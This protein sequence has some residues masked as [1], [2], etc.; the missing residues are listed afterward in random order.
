MVVAYPDLKLLSAVLVLLG[1]FRVVFP[2]RGSAIDR[3]SVRCRDT[4][5]VISLVLMIL[6]ISS[7]IVE[8]THTVPI[9]SAPFLP[10]W[11]VD[12]VPRTLFADQ[13]VIAVVGVVGISC[14]CASAIAN[15]PE[16]E[17]CS[18]VSSPRGGMWLSGGHK[19]RNS[20]PKRPEWP[21]LCAVSKM[22]ARAGRKR[23]L[24][25]PD[26]ER[27]AVG[28]HS[29]G[30]DVRCCPRRRVRAGPSATRLWWGTEIPP[31]A[32]HAGFHR[33]ARAPLRPPGRLPPGCRQLPINPRRAPS[34]LR[35]RTK[36]R[37]QLSL[38]DTCSS[39]PVQAPGQMSTK[40]NPGTCP[41]AP[42]RT[43]FSST[44]PRLELASTGHH[45]ET[46]GSPR[47]VRRPNRT[48]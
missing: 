34:R 43:P 48:I 44:Q 18:D 4:N 28:R 2:A 36:S 14:N 8:L 39:R 13:T 7:M 16:V 35:G 37:G 15:D 20:C 22:K 24:L 29:A 26:V 19:P 3:R 30:W 9:L 47:M 27:L 41:T 17:L 32:F 12:R 33:L 46:T 25:V 45:L 5:F 6:L 31:S 23:H 42:N 1:P 38:S 40:L 10:C 11:V 21:E